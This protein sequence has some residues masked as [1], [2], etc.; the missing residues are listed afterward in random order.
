MTAHIRHTNEMKFA[1]TALEVAY[2]TAR[3]HL[4]ECGTKWMDYAISH[5]P[6]ERYNLARAAEKEALELSEAFG[7]LATL[8]EREET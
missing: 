4:R 5:T 3:E 2:Y 1:A 7:R 8:A 6:E